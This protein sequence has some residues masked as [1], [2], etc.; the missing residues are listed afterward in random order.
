VKKT[1]DLGI[2]NRKIVRNSKPQKYIEEEY[3]ASNTI[4]IAFK[5]LRLE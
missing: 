1:Y 3:N 4:L 2:L 5:P